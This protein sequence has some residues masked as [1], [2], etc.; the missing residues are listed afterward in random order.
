MQSRINGIDIDNVQDIDIV[1][2]M[3]S[4]IEYGDN[5]SNNL[6]VYGNTTKMNSVITW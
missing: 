3:Y 4:L 2:P 5:Y 1:I 6:E